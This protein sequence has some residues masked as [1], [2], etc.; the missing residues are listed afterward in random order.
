MRLG[1][2][3]EDFACRYMEGK[4][5]EVVERSFRCPFGEI[6]IV[7]LKDGEMVFAEVK[8]RSTSAYGRPREAVNRAKLSRMEKCARYYLMKTDRPYHGVSLDVIEVTVEHIR[9]VSIR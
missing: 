1:A 8:T 5:Y 2:A 7:A 9:Q 6:D 4:G 3:G